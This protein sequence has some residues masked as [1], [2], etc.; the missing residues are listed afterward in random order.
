MTRIVFLTH[1]GADSGAEQSI[2]SYLARW[3]VSNRRPTLVL[4]RGG[5]IED[6][7]RDSDVECVTVELDAEVAGTRRNERRIGRLG[8][9]VVGLVKH[10]SKVHRFVDQRSTDVV[11]AISLKALVFGWLAGRRAGATVVWSLHDRV[12]R[13]YFPWFLVPV[14]RYVV[15]RLVDGIMVNSQSTLDTIR[16]GN[17]PVMIATPSIELDGR[18]F[19][20]PRDEV[21]RVIM[22]GRLTPW[23]GQD[24]FLESFASAFGDTDAEAYVVGGALFG[25]DAYEASLRRQAE[26]LGIAARVHFI[27]HVHDPW[28]WLVDADVLAHC[29]RIPEPFGRVVVQGLWAKCAVVAT[30]PGGPEEVLSDGYDGLLVPC[31]DE[32]ALTM[33]FRRLRDDRE[34]RRKLAEGGRSTARGYDAGVVAPALGAWLTRLHEGSVGRGSVNPSATHFP[35]VSAGH[36]SR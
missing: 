29:S 8:R 36:V 9:A 10:A 31:G 5:A 21:K 7:A 14:L 3:P 23:K 20:E 11:V 17:T 28:S 12:H 16:P 19:H 22:L 35:V 18:T 25:E 13:G 1:S 27:G 15:P 24:I 33:A 34:L 30:R 6:R 2:I 26:D 4:A 32:D